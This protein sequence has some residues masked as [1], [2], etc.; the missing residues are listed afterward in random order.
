MFMGEI[1]EVIIDDLIMQKVAWNKAPK[2]LKNLILLFPLALKKQIL[3]KFA[4]EI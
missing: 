3:N 2:P 1:D 4:Y